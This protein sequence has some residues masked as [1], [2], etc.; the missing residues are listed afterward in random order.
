VILI[1][2]TGYLAFSGGGE[3]ETRPPTATVGRK[4]RKPF[5]VTPVVSADGGGATF[6]LDW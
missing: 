5:S 3:T 6:Q 1:G 4:K 2:I